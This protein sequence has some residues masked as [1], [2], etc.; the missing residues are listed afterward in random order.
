MSTAHWVF[1]SSIPSSQTSCPV[2]CKYKEMCVTLGTVPP[3]IKSP[4]HQTH[5]ESETRTHTTFCPCSCVRFCQRIRGRLPNSATPSTW[6]NRHESDRF[7]NKSDSKTA[8][9][10]VASALGP[11]LSYQRKKND[12]PHPR[13]ECSSM[14]GLRRHKCVVCVSC[15]CAWARGS[16]G[17]H[18]PK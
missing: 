3:L 15:K 8:P 9:Q 17:N 6:A 2:P 13:T 11:L 7:Q 1:S 10:K 14:G 16:S 5:T 4:R 12:S 18:H